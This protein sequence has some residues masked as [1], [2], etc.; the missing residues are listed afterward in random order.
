MRESRI[1]TFDIQFT[2]LPSQNPVAKIFLCNPHCSM[3]NYLFISRKLKKQLAIVQSD[4][5]PYVEEESS[6]S[7]VSF[8]AAGAVAVLS[9]SLGGEMGQLGLEAAGAVVQGEL[10]DL[11]EDIRTQ[12]EMEIKMYS[13]PTQ[14]VK[15]LGTVSVETEGKKPLHVIKEQPVTQDV[16]QTYLLCKYYKIRLYFCVYTD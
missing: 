15:K 11:R 13:V 3:F 12:R 2:S 14:T 4:R 5:A 7:A 9:A 8:L 6:V 10:N 16:I 1:F